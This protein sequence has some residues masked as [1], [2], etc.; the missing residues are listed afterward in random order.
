MYHLDVSCSSTL[1]GLLVPLKS[2]WKRSKLPSHV[3][4]EV[5]CLLGYIWEFSEGFC[6]LDHFLF[7][8]LSGFM[9]HV[10]C[11]LKLLSSLCCALN[12]LPL[13][14]ASKNYQNRWVVCNRLFTEVLRVAELDHSSRQNRKQVEIKCSVLC[15]SLASPATWT[16]S[17]IV[18]LPGLPPAAMLLKFLAS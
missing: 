14:C 16:F 7:G 13:L 5:Q 18:F 11:L 8:I 6:T 9:C 4:W 12:T 17:S 1:L 2:K 15:I 10:S 3:L